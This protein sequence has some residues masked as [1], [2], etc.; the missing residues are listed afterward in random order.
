ML[1]YCPVL[2][3]RLL[4]GPSGCPADCK[5]TAPKSVERRLSAARRGYD[6]AWRSFRVDYLAAHPLC[7][8]CKQGG[9]AEA[10]TEIHH[11]IPLREGG[12][13]FD[14]WNLMALCQ[15]CHGAITGELD[16][17]GGYAWA[18][19]RLD[20]HDQRAAARG[21]RSMCFAIVLDPEQCRTPA[22]LKRC[23]A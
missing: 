5:R 13:K 19:A 23:P 7:R 16:G 3:C 21:L 18:M 9:R 6:R 14:G 20:R 12:P 15:G 10:S 1:R 4:V 8:I 11:V 17:R 2:G 22:A